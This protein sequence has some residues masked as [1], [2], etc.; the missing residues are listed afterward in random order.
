MDFP[1]GDILWQDRLKVLSGSGK[2]VKIVISWHADDGKKLTE[3]QEYEALNKRR[4]NEVRMMWRT[5]YLMQQVRENSPNF[6]CQ[7]LKDSLYL[8][9]PNTDFVE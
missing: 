4:Q 7:Y 3:T 5:S 9:N 8:W 1:F 2:D 6:K